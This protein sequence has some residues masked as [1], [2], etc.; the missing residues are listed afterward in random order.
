M[1]F[2]NYNRVTEGLQQNERYITLCWITKPKNQRDAVLSTAWPGINTDHNMAFETV[3][4]GELLTEQSCKWQDINLPKIMSRMN[5][6]VQRADLGPFCVACIGS[7]V[8]IQG[9][10][11]CSIVLLGYFAFPF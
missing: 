5:S 6:L 9:G 8:A 11:S 2:D 1:I 3:L 7:P 4:D 10:V